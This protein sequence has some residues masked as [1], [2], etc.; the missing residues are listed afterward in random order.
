MQNETIITPQLPPAVMADLA[1]P[2]SL[3]DSL[4]ALVA[5]AGER[6][7]QHYNNAAEIS[8]E[9]KADKSPVTQADHD[10][11][12]LLFTGLSALTPAV[13]VMS[14][15][16]PRE[17]IAGRRQW[18]ACWVV[19]PLDGTKEFLGRTGEFTINLALVLD[20]RPVL[21]IIAVPVEGVTYLGIPGE[22]QG[23]GAWRCSGAGLAT[24]ELLPQMSEHP[25]G[26]VRLLASQRHD[27]LK[28]ESVM[29]R[30]EP[31]ARAV[32]RVNA[33]SAI[34]FC[35]L[36]EG[37]AEIYPRTSPCYE[38]DVAAG[39]ALVHAAGGYL[40]DPDG[41]RLRYNARDTLLVEN[42]TAGLVTQRDWLNLL[43]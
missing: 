13:P 33:G 11:H 42:F 3:L 12:D 26:V 31:V 37:Q 7:L 2:V 1:L 27:P 40:V 23:A 39:D 8:V 18:R 15:E 19:D 14:E 36:I 28:V 29:Q 38:W 32:Q 5:A 17:E 20:E 10:S 41:Q 4:M 43:T 21:G 30:L 34:K 25:E 22:H 24:C 6:L 9:R 16:S 35:A